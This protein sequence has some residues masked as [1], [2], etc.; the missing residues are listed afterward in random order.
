MGRSPGK[1]GISCRPLDLYFHH[2][3]NRAQRTKTGNLVLR[4][5]ALHLRRHA[6]SKDLFLH[7]CSK[8]CFTSKQLPRKN[9]PILVVSPSWLQVPCI[10]FKQCLTVPPKTKHILKIN[11]LDDSFPLE[12]VPFLGDEF[13]HFRE[14]NPPAAQPV[15]HAATCRL[16]ES[17]NSWLQMEVFWTLIFLFKGI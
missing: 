2:H 3:Q 7:H 16:R 14:K 10:V 8:T 11:A 12:K 13:L 1:V 6:L 9:E 17:K 4:W 15:R 5:E